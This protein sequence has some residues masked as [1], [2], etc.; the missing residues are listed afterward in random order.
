MTRQRWQ[1][2]PPRPIDWEMRSLS[3]AETS[4]RTMDDGRKELLIRHEELEAVTPEMLLWWFHHLEETMEWHGAIV[5]RYHV[6]HPIDHIQFSVERRAVDG[7]VGPGAKWHIVEAL[8]RES[9]FPSGRESRCGPARYRW[10]H[11]GRPSPRSNPASARAH[12][13]THAPW[14]SIRDA[15]APRS[16]LLAPETH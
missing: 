16:S 6:W 2:L 12:L 14:H 10:H 15:N 9:R 13:H 11:T 5:P 8:R 4:I 1:L 7:S 3:S